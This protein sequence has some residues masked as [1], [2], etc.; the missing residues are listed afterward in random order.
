[1]SWIK[2]KKYSEKERMKIEKGSG[3]EKFWTL[4][5]NWLWRVISW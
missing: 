4:I 3:F 2:S 1:M 5:C